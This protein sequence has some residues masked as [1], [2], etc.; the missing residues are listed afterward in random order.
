M[1]AAWLFIQL[2]AAPR[3]TPIKFASELIAARIT[4]PM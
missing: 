3:I 1:D 2:H 4:Q